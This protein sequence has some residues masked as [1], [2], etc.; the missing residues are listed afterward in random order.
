MSA[1][2]ESYCLTNCEATYNYIG[3]ECWELWLVAL[4]C[5]LNEDEAN[6]F[7]ADDGTPDM[8]I[9]PCEEEYDAF[10]GCEY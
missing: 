9:P 8:N 7:C 6:W 3:E 4:N 10:S 5:G 2:E 1:W